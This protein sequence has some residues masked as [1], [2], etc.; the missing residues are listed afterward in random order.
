MTPKRRAINLSCFFNN[1]NTPIKQRR[2]WVI[3]N[4]GSNPHINGSVPLAFWRMLWQTEVTGNV[5]SE[6]LHEVREAIGEKLSEPL[7]EAFELCTKQVEKAISI[8]LW[9]TGGKTSL[10]SKLG[11]FS[12]KNHRPITCL[13]TTYKW[14]TLCLLKPIDDHLNECD[15]MEGEQRGAKEQCSGTIDNLLIDRMVCQDCQRGRR[16]LCMAWI[17]VRK[18][19]DS[20]DHHV[21]HWFREM[22][23]LHRFPK[24]IGNLT[25]RQK[26]NTRITVR[27]KKVVETSERIMF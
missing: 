17:E 24:W 25:E 3:V 14:F 22:F 10:I 12:S 8:P 1:N 4:S 20:V 15:L 13:N 26:W 18:A 11:E 21:H 7:E 27:T 6:W 19:Y 16:N 9:F 2:A 5:A 23:S